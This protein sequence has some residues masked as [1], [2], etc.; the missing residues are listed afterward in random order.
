MAVLEQEQRQRKAFVD[1]HRKTREKDFS[2]GK[3]VLVFR[4]RMGQMPRKLRFKW[5]RPY[6]IVDNNNGTYQHDTLAGE[7]FPKWG[8]GF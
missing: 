7:L 5:T 8:N 6:W 2:V 1:R 4:T 3:A